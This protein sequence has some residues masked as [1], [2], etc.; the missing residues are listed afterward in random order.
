VARET[1]SGASRVVYALYRDPVSSQLLA[2]SLEHR[3]AR[4][5][6][7]IA[8]LSRSAS[9]DDGHVRAAALVLDAVLAHHASGLGL[10]VLPDGSSIGALSGSGRFARYRRIRFSTTVS[11][12]RCSTGRSRGGDAGRGRRSRRSSGSL[13]V[14]TTRTAA[15][16]TQTA[17]QTTT[18]ATEQ[19]AQPRATRAKAWKTSGDKITES[20]TESASKARSEARKAGRDEV[21]E[22]STEAGKAAGNE[23]AEASAESR[24]ES[25]TKT[26]ELR[27]GHGA[28]DTGQ[29][30]DLSVG[31]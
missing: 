29:D 22:T 13:I 30:E 2:E 24:A 14:R 3:W 7:D 20:T 9:E 12:V 15:E 10:A 31:S 21:A 8:G 1:Y 23:V 5:N 18:K 26:G 25:G 16:T 11:R 17:A 28:G 4:D 27:V 19:A 6:T